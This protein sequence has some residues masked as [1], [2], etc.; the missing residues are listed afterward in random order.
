VRHGLILTASGLVVGL[1]AAIALTRL[2]S[3]ILYGVS[4]TDV[5]TFTGVSVLL[6]MVAVFS[7]LIPALR[8]SKVDPVRALRYE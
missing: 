6:A 8:A 3:A 4:A 1:G 7:G 5:L 2:M